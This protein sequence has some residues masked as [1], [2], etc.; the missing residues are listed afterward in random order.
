MVWNECM[1]QDKSYLEVKAWKAIESKALGGT[2]TGHESVP[3][4]HT[5][6][7]NSTAR[8][9]NSKLVFVLVSIGMKGREGSR[10]GIF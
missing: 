8:Y 4:Y 9:Y 5:M 7:R 2:G 6:V 10:Q 3:V 1:V